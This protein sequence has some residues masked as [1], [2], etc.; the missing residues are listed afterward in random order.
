MLGEELHKT[1]ANAD[2][3]RRDDWTERAWIACCECIGPSLRTD[4]SQEE[5]VTCCV[6]RGIDTKCLLRR[7]DGAIPERSDSRDAR[8]SDP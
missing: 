5:A 3:A 8:R 1:E 2:E 4:K 6:T 7:L